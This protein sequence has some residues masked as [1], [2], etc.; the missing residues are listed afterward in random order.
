MTVLKIESMATMPN[1]LKPCSAVAAVS[2]APE[3]I[4]NG[5]A[6]IPIN[7][8]A[9]ALMLMADIA[10]K[11]GISRAAIYTHFENK[12]EIFKVIVKQTYSDTLEQ[13]AACFAEKQ[14]FRNAFHSVVEK[15]YQNCLKVG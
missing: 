9:A 10:E 1:A 14:S 11:A 15:K 8:N 6:I 12:E 3:K 4:T 13:T 2:T 5:T 7:P